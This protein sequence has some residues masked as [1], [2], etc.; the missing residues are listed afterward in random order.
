MRSLFTLIFISFAVLVNGQ[1]PSVQKSAPLTVA[2]PESVGMS[3]ERLDRIDAM[4]REAVKDGEVPGIVTL[5]ARHGKIVF[6]EAYGMADNQSDRK[7]KKDFIAGVAIRRGKTT[8][9]GVV[10][11][12]DIA[13]IHLQKL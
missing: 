5:V 9:E 13:T 7:M 11:G 2:P 8:K 12:N 1:T 6:H 3:A 4:C 10:C